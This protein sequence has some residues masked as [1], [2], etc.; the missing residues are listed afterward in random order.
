[1]NYYYYTK[2]IN[3]LNIKNNNKKKNILNFIRNNYGTINYFIK[4]W[5]DFELR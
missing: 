3:H 5:T 2:N 4:I 1:M